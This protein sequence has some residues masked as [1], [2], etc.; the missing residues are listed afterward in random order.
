MVYNNVTDTLR[1]WCEQMSQHYLELYEQTFAREGTN[2]H[3][4]SYRVTD[5]FNYKLGTLIDKSFPCFEAYQNTVRALLSTRIDAVLEREEKEAAS[6]Y[7]RV[8]EE[9]FFEYFTTISAD[10]PSP[11]TPYNRILCGEE[12]EQVAARIFDV[13]GYDTSYWYPLNDMSG[14]DKLF[15]APKRIKPYL[16]EIY[17]LLGLP[18]QHIYQYGEDG[19]YADSFCAEVEK[20][21]EYGGVEFVYCAKDFSWLI[22]YS[23]EN[24]VTFAGNIVPRIKEILRAEQDYWNRFED[25]E[26]TD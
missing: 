26:E 16:G 23:H 1:A 10:C 18:Q 2:K 8:A 21:E 25:R 3:Y 7:I 6:S 14:E 12:A 4:L 15:L 20:P 17:R 22:Y 9:A 24:T 13:W 11:N 5:E 19:I